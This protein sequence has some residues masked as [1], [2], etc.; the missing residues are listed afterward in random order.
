MKIE[1]SNGFAEIDE[2]F[3]WL[4]GE[5]TKYITEL[6]RPGR[7]T[8][9]SLIAA[10]DVLLLALLKKLNVG[11]KDLPIVRSS[12]DKVFPKDR[13]KIITACN[14]I[15]DEATVDSTEKKS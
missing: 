8:V 14:K 3:E 4:W 5:E 7:V 13:E 6:H 2:T 15:R 11:D 9:S 1:L 12:L 10:E